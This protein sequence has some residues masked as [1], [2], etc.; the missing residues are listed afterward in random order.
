[1]RKIDL[2]GKR[3]GRLEVI[4]C[5]GHRGKARVWEC[6]CDCGNSC[7]VL[8]KSLQS[9]KTSSCGCYSKELLTKRLTKHGD[10]GTRLYD[11]W[12]AIK[13]RCYNESHKDY[14]DYGGRGIAMCDEW[15]NN[16]IA[17]RDWALSNGYQENLTIDRI[18][19]NKNY[20]LDNCRWIAKSE[21]NSNKRN[22]H[23]I[24]YNG[25]T[26][27][28]TE[29]AEITGI[30]RSTLSARIVLNNWPIEKALTQEVRKLNRKH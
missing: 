11:I 2:T 14:Q 21:Q 27:T 26:R 8:G 28:L 19:V 25:E 24:T 7:V 22:N 4:R 10:S 18:D 16:Y 23:L 13:G 6:M 12:C 29:W 3:F 20:E 1:M 9:G 17:F 5:A 15:K 30:P